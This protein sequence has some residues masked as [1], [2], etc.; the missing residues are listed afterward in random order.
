MLV[1][2]KGSVSDLPEELPSNDALHLRMG[3]D[4]YFVPDHRVASEYM[5]EAY[6]SP[7]FVCEN[8]QEELEAING[9]GLHPHVHWRGGDKTRRPQGILGGWWKQRIWKDL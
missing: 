5:P 6:F 8:R 1:I 7:Q 2:T 3:M 9:H 4:P